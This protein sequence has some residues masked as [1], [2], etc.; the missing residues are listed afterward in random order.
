MSSIDHFNLWSF[1]LNLLV[2]F[3]A[4]MRERSVTRAAGRLKIQ[5]SAMSHNL[6]TLR[7]LLDDEL[8]VRVGHA[9]K[10]TARAEALSAAISRILEQAQGAITMRETFRPEREERTFSIGFSS[11]LEVLLMPGLT[12]HVRR[13]APGIRLLARPAQPDEVHRM[14]DDGELDLA[15][16]CFGGGAER[17]RGKFLFEQ[18]LLCCFNPALL[19]LAVPL[20]R[21]AYL[22]QRHALVSQNASIRGCLE[23]AVHA[24]GIELDVAMAAPEFLTVLSTVMQTPVIATLPARIV[25]RFAPLMGLLASPVPFDF[26]VTPIS[27][28]WAAQSDRDPASEWLRQLVEPVLAQIEGGMPSYGTVAA[29]EIA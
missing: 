29:N 2:A 18:S 10:P 24:A 5:Q 21:D 19:N 25:N 9:M 8:F 27:M 16:G 17:H 3:D 12:A 26:A 13:L 23:D 1:D 28:L 22:T 15:V 6:G 20:S 4:L 11:E 7:V 14:L